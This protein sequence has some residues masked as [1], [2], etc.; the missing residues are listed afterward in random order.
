MKFLQWNS[1]GI[2]KTTKNNK[3]INEKKTKKEKISLEKL[4][5]GKRND[6]W[7]EWKIKIDFW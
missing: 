6:G 5:Q 2:S 7:H 1:D 4:K 3:K